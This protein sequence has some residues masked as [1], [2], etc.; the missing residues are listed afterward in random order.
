MAYCVPST[1]SGPQTQNTAPSPR[2]HCHGPGVEQQ[3]QRPR[4]EGPEQPRTPKGGERDGHE[5][6]R[7]AGDDQHPIKRGFAD[8][9]LLKRVD[10]VAIPE[11]VALIEAPVAVGGVVQQIVRSVGQQSPRTVSAHS[12]GSG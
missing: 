12:M 3:A 2:P 10:S 6:R 7:T 8:Q 4:Q 5:R 1:I 9:P 11:V